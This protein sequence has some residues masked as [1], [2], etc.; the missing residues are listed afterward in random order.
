MGVKRQPCLH[1]G[2]PTSDGPRCAGCALPDPYGAEYERNRRAMLANA[3]VCWICDE[4]ARPG[5]PLTADHVLAAIAGG[6]PE[7]ENLAPAHGTCNSRRGA[8]ETPGGPKILPVRPGADPARSS[9][10]CTGSGI[11]DPGRSVAT[12][13]NKRSVP[14]G[15]R[16]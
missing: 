7:I 4:P 13:D 16:S 8:L 3:E 15:G 2:R 1:C 10:P 6:G 9:F 12:T 14:A 5:D 11:L